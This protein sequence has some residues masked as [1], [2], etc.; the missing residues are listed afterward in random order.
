MEAL[1]NIALEKGALRIILQARNNAVEF[2]KNNGFA[3]VEKSYILFDE[4][5][6]W[7]MRKELK[8]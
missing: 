6:H 4:I 7:L 1:E 8:R 5:Q 2:Y 3:I